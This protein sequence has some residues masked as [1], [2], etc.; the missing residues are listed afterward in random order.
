[1]T[2]YMLVISHQGLARDGGREGSM[3]DSCEELRN[4][5]HWS[6]TSGVRKDRD[7]K[8]MHGADDAARVQPKTE[9]YSSILEPS[10]VAS[11]AETLWREW[12]SKTA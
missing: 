5:G 12:T 10:I 6:E 1:M 2:H 7:I 11:A 4:G 8:I 9:H 3:V